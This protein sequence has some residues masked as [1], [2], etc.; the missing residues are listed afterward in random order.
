MVRCP[1]ADAKFTSIVEYTP[2]PESNRP[3]KSSSATDRGSNLG[4]QGNVRRIVKVGYY[5]ATADHIAVVVVLRCL[6]ELT[7]R[8]S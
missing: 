1:I 6:P 8:N 7:D 5:V 3:E 4:R 2:V